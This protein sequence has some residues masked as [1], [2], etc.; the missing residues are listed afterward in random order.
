[1]EMYV[2]SPGFHPQYS[3]LLYSDSGDGGKGGQ[4]LKDTLNYEV[5]LR[6][7]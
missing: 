6:L 2:Q 7:A 4:K 5:N 1:M 3:T